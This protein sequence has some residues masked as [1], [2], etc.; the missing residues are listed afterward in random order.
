M[1]QGAW[2]HVLLPKLCVICHVHILVGKQLWWV[3]GESR[4]P[5]AHA[6]DKTNYIQS[7]VYYLQANVTG[8]RSLLS[9]S[10]T[11][12]TI[13]CTFLHVC[14]HASADINPYTHTFPTPPHVCD[15]APTI[16][17]TISMCEPACLQSRAMPILSGQLLKHPYTMY[18]E[19]FTDSSTL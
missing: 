11:S 16:N 5:P 6:K 3:Q 7:Y 13:R 10:A 12:L 17:P 4:L 1:K 15:L 18:C 19:C 9:L 2:E 8:N 14:A